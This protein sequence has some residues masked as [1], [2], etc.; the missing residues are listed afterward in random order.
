MKNQ[1]L[2]GRIQRRKTNDIR[3]QQIG[4]ELNTA[5]IQTER[6]GKGFRERRLARAGQILE[7][8]M[9]A[10]EQTGDRERNHL[11]LADDNRRELIERLMQLLLQLRR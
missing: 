2:R 3:R 9:P 10:R 5:K 11:L 4:G 6:R 8:Q 7:Q 1:R